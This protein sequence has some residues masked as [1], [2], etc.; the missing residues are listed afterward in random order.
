MTDRVEE[1]R[2]E[3]HDRCPFIREPYD[4][5]TCEMPDGR[6]LTRCED[7]HSGIDD[8]AAVRAEQQTEINKAHEAL[9]VAGVAR[10]AGG[11][12]LRYRIGLLTEEAE[13]HTEPLPGD[14]IVETDCPCCGAELSVQHGDDPGE[15]GCYGKGGAEQSEIVSL[16]PPSVGK[17]PRPSD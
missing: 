11:H 9:D 4:G 10:G 8:L 17:R 3:A 2:R 16:S 5:Q 1:A 15:I 6:M 12:S 13:Q 7:L 14:V